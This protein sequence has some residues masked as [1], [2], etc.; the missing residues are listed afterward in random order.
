MNNHEIKRRASNYANSALRPFGNAQVV[1]VFV[2][3]ILKAIEDAYI[4]GV[5]DTL[6]LPLPDKLTAIESLQIKDLYKDALT[7]FNETKSGESGAY[8]KG[9]CDA[10]ER[11]FSLQFLQSR[12][13]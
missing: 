3:D 7:C 6:A 1:G 5:N 11:I 13:K 9:Y 4:K 2:S 8:P 10:I 12:S